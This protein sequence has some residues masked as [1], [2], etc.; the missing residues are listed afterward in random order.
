MEDGQ[1][2]MLVMSTFL[3]CVLKNGVGTFS[4]VFI[5]YLVLISN[6]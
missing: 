6:L 5:H 4:Y 1:K 2:K 3:F